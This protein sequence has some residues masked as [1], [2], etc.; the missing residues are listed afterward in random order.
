MEPQGLPHGLPVPPPPP[1]PPAQLAAFGMPPLATMQ[2][3]AP[4]MQQLA[5]PMQQHYMPVPPP[6]HLPNMA[7]P[8]PPLQQAYMPPPMQPFVPLPPARPPVPV[9]Q[10][11]PPLPPQPAPALAAP[12]IEAV[13][14]DQY[15]SMSAEQQARPGPFHASR[16]PD[17]ASA[18]HSCPPTTKPA[19]RY[20]P[21]PC[22]RHCGHS[23]RRSSSSSS[24]SSSRR[25]TINTRRRQ[26]HRRTARRRLSQGTSVRRRHPR[27]TMARLPTAS[28]RQRP[29]MR[30]RL[31]PA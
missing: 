14:Q 18:H 2:Q 26:H 1:L 21:F 5:P 9:Q 13:T 17:A 25:P 24:S 20:T 30:R 16:G 3:L 4:P 7:P 27:P 28:Y 19:E 6:Q 10:P 23:T 22:R 12:T 11:Y 31:C 8:L 29:A 15:Q